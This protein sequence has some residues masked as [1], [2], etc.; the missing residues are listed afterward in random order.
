MRI[1]AVAVR[2]FKRIKDINIKP[3]ADRSIILIGGKNAQ[4][5]T[6]LLDALTVAFGGKKMQ[7]ADP[8]RRGADD[9]EILIELDGGD[10]T[11]RR[12]IDA[13]GESTL[14][15][16]SPMGAVKAPQETLDKLIS[17]RFLDPHR[18]LSQPAKEQRAQL[19]RLIGEADRI[20]QLDAKRELA[21]TKR[22][23]VG[24]DL[25]KAEGELARLPAVEPGAPIDVAELTLAA[26][27]V[28]AEQ[29]ER[30]RLASALT[31]AET[32]AMVE[33]ASLDAAQQRISKIENELAELRAQLPAK[34]TSVRSHERDVNAAKER[35]A[36]ADQKL[37]NMAP[38]RARIEADIARADQHNRT[39]YA[40][41]AHMQRRAEA[42]ETVETLT[43][44]RDRIKGFLDEI[45]HRKT[46]ILAEA[47][48][49]VEGLGFDGEGVTLNGVP[50][51]QASGAE[52]FRVA[53]ALAIAASPG[54]DDVWI[55]DAAVLDDDAISMIA[56]QAAAAG[57]RP[58][59]ERVGTR[60]PGVIVIS[61]GKVAS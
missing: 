53:L 20:A 25:A 60:D 1:T 49:P 51:A 41:Q 32:L 59:L 33:R 15:V 9:A 40:Q 4:G 54:L 23:E 5:K 11:I 26:Q 3:D 7:P 22:T 42:I 55:R 46:K 39:V 50:L 45:D 35:L 48:L 34:E 52:R 61:D 47:K 6:S 31:Q 14:E 58:W 10:L 12:Q 43:A 38:E 13:S 18:F 28:A 37:S 2:D 44:E 57:K 24:R 29:R 8:V 30:D 17:G 36:A 19:M 16:R 21:F 56:E 27:T